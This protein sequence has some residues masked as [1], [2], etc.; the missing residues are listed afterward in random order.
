MRSLR[1]VHLVEALGVGGIERVV[2]TLVRNTP[3][4]A[5]A[6]VIC[7]AGGGPLAEEIEAAGTPVRV[8]HVSSYYPACIA[9]TALA[10]KEKRADVVHSHGHFAGV[11][12]RAAAWWAR[13]PVVIHHLH[14]ID[15][16]LL[17]RHRRLERALAQI[18]RAHV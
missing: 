15:T 1:I 2:Q 16:T 18:G 17:P 4:G 3:A 5:R 14:T 6:E 12:G 9:R 11:L 8:L 13:V 7:A 10:L